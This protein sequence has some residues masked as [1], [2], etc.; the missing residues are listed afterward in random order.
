MSSR[1]REEN[2]FRFARTRFALDALDSYASAP[3]DPREREVIPRRSSTSRPLRVVIP[4]W[5][6]TAD[7]TGKIQDTPRVLTHVQCA[8][9]SR[10]YKTLAM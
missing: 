9:R 3:D 1:W 8:P 10:L 2:Y 7:I 5:P 6:P 4:K